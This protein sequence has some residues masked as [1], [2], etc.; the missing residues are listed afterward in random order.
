MKLSFCGID[1][2]ACKFSVE[3]GQNCPGCHAIKGKPFWSTDGTCELYA[4]ADG[5]KLHNCG[6]CGEFPCR[7]LIDAHKGENPNGNGIEIE[8]LRKYQ[9]IKVNIQNVGS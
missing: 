8:N 9:S 5:K 4:C 2:A 3:Q 6:K 1:C 7:K